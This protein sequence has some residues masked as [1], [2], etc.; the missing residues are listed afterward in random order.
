MKEKIAFSGVLLIFACIGLLVTKGN[1]WAVGLGILV[2]SV[3]F[4]ASYGTRTAR[5]KLLNEQ[6]LKKE[7][8]NYALAFI[9]VPS[10]LLVLSHAIQL[11]QHLA[12]AENFYVLIAH[13]F[14]VYALYAI[15]KFVFVLGYEKQAKKVAKE[16]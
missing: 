10:V 9:A 11:P 15:F 2:F 5:K 4:A 14:A 1:L 3:S 12:L 6:Q 7:S 16:G 8:R 13:L